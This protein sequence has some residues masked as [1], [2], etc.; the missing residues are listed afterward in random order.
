MMLLALFADGSTA[1]HVFGA[2]ALTPLLFDFA[3][4]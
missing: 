1:P 2:D 4:Q 3:I